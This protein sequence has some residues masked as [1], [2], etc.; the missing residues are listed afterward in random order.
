MKFSVLSSI[1]LNM[2]IT[3][4]LHSVIDNASVW[5][6]SVSVSIVYFFSC[7]V[8]LYVWQFL[9]ECQTLHMKSY[10]DSQ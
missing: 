2:L 5:I 3:V 7:P 4:I 8:P 9:I 10:K 6:I 1:F